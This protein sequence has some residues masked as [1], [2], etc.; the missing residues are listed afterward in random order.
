MLSLWKLIPLLRTSALSTSSKFKNKYEY[1]PKRKWGLKPED[2]FA[3]ASSTY[4]VSG[5]VVPGTSSDSRTVWAMEDIGREGQAKAKRLREAKEA[6]HALKALV[7]RDKD[8][9]K[10]LVRAM[11]ISGS[12]ANASKKNSQ[13]KKGKG[14]EEAKCGS[15]GVETV[16]CDE[17]SES[18]TK[19][20]S[21]SAVFVKALG[22]DPSLK[23]GP[24]K[25][26]DRGNEKVDS[27]F[28]S[29][30]RLVDGIF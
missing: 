24:R 2:S 12:E 7:N 11:E 18:Q 29:P 17:K 16:K 8:G 27:C 1:D 26:T 3:A 4:V 28:L 20:S 15:D 22:F 5:H 25:P 10:L 19:G 30:Y 21:Y 6:D 23:G 14:K 13:R 9:T